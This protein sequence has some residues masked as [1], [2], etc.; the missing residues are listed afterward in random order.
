MHLSLFLMSLLLPQTILAQNK[1]DTKV[2]GLNLNTALQTIEKNEPVSPNLS[3][4]LK[5]NNINI[6]LLW[7]SWCDACK[8]IIPKIIEKYPLIK[9]CS[10]GLHFIALRD[11]V[12]A[13]AQSLSKVAPGHSTLVDRNNVLKKFLNLK[14]IP[15]VLIVDNHGNILEMISGKAVGKFPMQLT[16][17]YKDL[18]CAKQ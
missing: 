7:A 16:K 2:Q 8:S 10:L 9:S 3:S 14:I 17:K 11:T 12:P 5:K 13:A 4:E 15:T 1:I 6:I 18:S